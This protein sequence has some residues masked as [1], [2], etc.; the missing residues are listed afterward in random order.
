MDVTVFS[1]EGY[2]IRN[3][4]IGVTAG[5][6]FDSFIFKQKGKDN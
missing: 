4:S 1:N 6:I 5:D 3:I 2:Q